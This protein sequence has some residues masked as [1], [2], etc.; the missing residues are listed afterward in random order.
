MS[1]MCTEHSTVARWV[2][3]LWPWLENDLRYPV[4]VDARKAFWR[5]E[6]LG[7]IRIDL[8]RDH[9]GCRVAGRTQEG[10]TRHGD[11]RLRTMLASN[12]WIMSWM[13]RR[14]HRCGLSMDDL[15]ELA[16]D[17]AAALRARIPDRHIHAA[18]MAIRAALPLDPGILAL[19]ERSNVLPTLCLGHYAA[20]AR[21]QATL[22]ERERLAP[23]LAA[24][25]A[26]YG[27]YA[28]PA[29]SADSHGL[30]ARLD[31]VGMSKA[32]WRLLLRHGATLWRGLRRSHEFARRPEAMLVEWARL[33]ALLPP[34]QSL[35]ADRIAL[36][37]AQTNSMRHS[38]LDDDARFQ[39]RLVLAASRCWDCLPDR[40]E[41]RRWSREQLLPVLAWAQSISH[42]APPVPPGAGF[43]WYL[44]QARAAGTE[45]HLRELARQYP[46]RPDQG[47]EF[48][49]LRFTRLRS[50]AALYRAGLSFHNCLVQV[51]NDFENVVSPGSH[52]AITEP[53]SGRALAL[54]RADAGASGRPL[55]VL[56]LRGPCNRPVPIELRN[57][58]RRFVRQ[59]QGQATAARDRARVREQKARQSRVAAPRR[60]FI[61][62]LEDIGV[63]ATPD[64]L[65]ALSELDTIFN[66]PPMH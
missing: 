45:N 9:C 24:T 63:P 25:F 35:P 44:R 62:S 43:A 51:A 58:V 14:A 2:E 61:K 50:R 12:D 31:E 29:Y 30:K 16:D 34:Q 6:I 59:N 11:L 23:G 66:R 26:Q 64:V 10:F 3:T 28:G 20:V 13:W 32:G 41:R 40:I 27:C 17:V 33:V 57:T 7:A 4:H 38:A 55:S 52:Y 21:N 39:A 49:N 65:H 54:L 5:I 8:D 18:R 42:A 48:E 19:A 22:R 15:A 36:V 53:G 37:W 60:A 46:G 56:E 1:M 47:F